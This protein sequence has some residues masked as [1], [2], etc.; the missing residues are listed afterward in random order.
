MARRLTGSAPWVTLAGVVVLLLGLGWDARLHRLRPE[1]AAQEGIFTLAN[2]GHGLFG[3]GIALCIAGSLLFLLGRAAEPGVRSF[4]GRAALS[5]TAAMV[6]LLAVGSLALARS[7]DN[8]V[9]GGHTHHQARS[10]EPPRADDHPHGD[11]PAGHSASTAADAILA[12]HPHA[13][14]HAQAGPHI[15]VTAS[16]PKTPADVQ[17]G[18][19]V[20]QAA[21]ASL[22]RYADHR[23]AQQDGYDRVTPAAPNGEVHFTNHRNAA[24]AASRFDP[25]RPTSLLYKRAGDGYRLVGAMYTAPAGLSEDKLDERIPTSVVPW[26][27]HVDIC[28]PPEGQGRAMLG[29]APRFGPLSSI[30]TETE[31]AAAGG[32]FF[33][34]LFGW[35]VHVY[36]FD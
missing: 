13:P 15:R 3:L 9:T 27:M 29:P 11:D 20:M 18:D 24:L 35:M 5:G 22:E 14:H 1:L 17:R 4:V 31:C 23:L 32:R 12:R 28:L 26:H 19:G 2:P 21:R 7:A 36:P 6:L 16:R 10:A 25:T 30:T 8:A 34:R 33:P